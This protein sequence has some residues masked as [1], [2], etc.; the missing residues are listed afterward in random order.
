MGW[1]LINT[2]IANLQSNINRR[3]LE[4]TQLQNK[5]YNAT[6]YTSALGDGIISFDEYCDLN[7]ENRQSALEYAYFSTEAADN[8]IGGIT[9]S[10]LDAYGNASPEVLE[11]AGVSMY[12]AEGGGLDE[13]KLQAK[14][15]KDYLAQFAQT[16]ASGV[17][18]YE[19]QLDN[20]IQLLLTLN[21]SEQAELQSLK[22]QKS[23]AIQQSTIRLS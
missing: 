13:E 15:Y 2:R 3:S 14:L 22:E 17:A 11:Q 18:E 8:A 6:T 9:Q 23:Q 7:Q 4:L 20:E 10:Y 21:E 5:K 1:V 12:Q 19:K 16:A